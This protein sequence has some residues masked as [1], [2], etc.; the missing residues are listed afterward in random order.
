MNNSK[1]LKHVNFLKE[2]LSSRRLVKLIKSH[3]IVGKNVCLTS[4]ASRTA[5]W[6][7]CAIAPSLVVLPYRKH[8]RRKSLLRKENVRGKYCYSQCVNTRY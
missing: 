3:P 7:S 6:Q 5:E 8:F 1:I 2:M 4:K